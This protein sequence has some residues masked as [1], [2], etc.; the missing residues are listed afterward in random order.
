RAIDTLR[1]QQSQE[2]KYAELGQ[3]LHDNGRL[4]VP[5]VDVVLEDG[6]IE[7]DLLKLIFMCCH[8]LLS[9]EARVALT[10]RTLGGLKTCEIARAL[11]LTEAAAAQRIVRAKRTLKESGA[12]FALPEGRERTERLDSVFEVIYLIFNEGYTATRGSDL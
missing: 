3:E 12:S 1:R 10:L 5:A 11:L 6:D 4:Y 7:D 8:P 2:R 9:R